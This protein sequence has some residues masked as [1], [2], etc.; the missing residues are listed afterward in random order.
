MFA[1]M[2]SFIFL[3]CFL[4]LFILNSSINI[5]SLA[6]KKKAFVNFKLKS[7]CLRLLKGNYIVAITSFKYTTNFQLFYF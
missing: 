7:K 3:Y 1:K 5:E 2:T 6:K 4:L